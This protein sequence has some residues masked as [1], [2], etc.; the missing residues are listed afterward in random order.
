RALGRVLGARPRSARLWRAAADVATR[1]QAGSCLRVL[2]CRRGHVST[3]V[4]GDLGLQ[5]S[6]ANRFLGRTIF[7]LGW[8]VADSEELRLRRVDQL[9]A[10]FADRSQRAPAEVE[11]R[12]ERFGIENA[13]GNI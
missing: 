8:I 11:Q 13:I 12:C 5:S 10:S 3:R 6:H 7:R 2:L 9:P 4:A 1:L